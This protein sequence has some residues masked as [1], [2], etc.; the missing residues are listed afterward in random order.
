MYKVGFHLKNCTPLL[1][2]FTKNPK[3]LYPSLYKKKTMKCTICKT[4]TVEHANLLWGWVTLEADRQQ[5]F[6][7]GKYHCLIYHRNTNCQMVTQDI[8]Y[9]YIS[10]YICTYIYTYL[11]TYITYTFIYIRKWRK[12]ERLG[13][14]EDLRFQHWVCEK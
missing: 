1:C 10:T 7:S 5:Y 2:F 14:L 6:S 12:T 4:D 8:A 11:Y 3:T 9:T 13:G